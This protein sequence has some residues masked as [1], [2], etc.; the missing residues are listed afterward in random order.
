LRADDAAIHAQEKVYRQGHDGK[1]TKSERQQLTRELKSD[2]P[3]HLSGSPRQSDAEVVAV[4]AGGRRSGCQ[5]RCR[6]GDRTMLFDNL[7]QP[8]YWP[9]AVREPFAIVMN[10]KVFP[11]CEIRQSPTLLS[12]CVATDS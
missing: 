4:D 5:P 9:S 3:S 11:T 6:R 2:E 8:T 12:D 10:L 7:L 1:L